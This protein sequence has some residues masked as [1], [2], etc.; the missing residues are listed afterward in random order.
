MNYISALVML[1]RILLIAFTVL[2]SVSSDAKIIDR[3]VAYVDYDAITSVDLQ[4]FMEDLKSRAV[5]TTPKEAVEVLINRKIFIKEARRLKLKARTDEALIEKYIDIKIK[6]FIFVKDEEI[7]KYYREHLDVFKD[8]PFEELREQLRK[9]VYEKK[10]NRAIKEHIRKLR[11]AHN[12]VVIMD[13][14]K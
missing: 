5:K 12:V 9:V 11:K 2:Q 1:F 13:D 8:K 6:P 3:I 14:L 7:L 4:R 10:L